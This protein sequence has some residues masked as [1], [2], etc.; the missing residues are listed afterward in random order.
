MDL[1]ELL[2]DAYKEGMTFEEAEVALKAITPPDSG[3]ADLTKLKADLAKANAATAKYKE[4]L[5]NKQMA[6]EAAAAAKQEEYDKLAQENAELKR[7]MALAERK[8]KLLAMG[9]E[10]K[11]AENTAAAMVDGDMDTVLT[12]QSQY[13]EAQKK[14]ILADKMK[15][16]PRPK[17]GAEGTGGMD[18]Q[19]K[20]EEA[21]ASGDYSAAAY[22]TRLSQAAAAKND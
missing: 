22:Y 5:R 16:T 15:Q 10:E 12:N 1:K 14:A 21:Q 3:G 17:Q 6:D 8:A 7:S 4:Q 19:K 2:G 13:F 20:I 9:Y 11:L 18:Y